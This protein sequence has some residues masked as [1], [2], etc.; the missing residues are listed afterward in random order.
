MIIN[1]DE[2][3]WQ[4]QSHDDFSCERKSLTA[5]SSAQQLGASVFKLAPGKKAFPYHYHHANE[6]AILVL[7]GAGSARI[8]DK[9]H[10]I[11]TNDYIAFPAGADHAHQVINTSDQDLIY[12][13]FSTMITPEVCEYPDSDKICAMAG[14]APGGDKS[15]R[16][17]MACFRTESAVDYFDGES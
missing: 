13:C 7:Q 16:Q 17:L 6:E 4:Q 3:D 1:L 15:N 2:L 11:K 5:A 12:L 8:N 10:P 14:S 9:I